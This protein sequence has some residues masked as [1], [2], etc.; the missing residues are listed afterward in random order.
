MRWFHVFTSLG[1]VVCVSGVL[2]LMR[3]D[4]H[5]SRPDPSPFFPASDSEVL[6]RQVPG[7]GSAPSFGGTPIY[8]AC[9]LVTIDSLTRLGVTLNHDRV[10]MHD[11]LDGDV[12]PE[13]AFEQPGDFVSG[14][15]YGLSNG[16]ALLVSVYQTPYI[17]PK[18]LDFQMGRPERAGAPTRTEDGLSIAHVELDDSV[19]IRLWKPGLLVVVTLQ[20]DKP[21]PYG[22]LDAQTFATRL[23]TIAK[24]ALSHGPTAPMRH[25]YTSLLDKVKHPCEVVSTEVFLAS[26]PSRSAA[27]VQTQFH[28][29]ASLTPMERHPESALQGASLCSRH[30][31][32]P[33]GTT[34]KAEYRELDLKITWWDKTQAAVDLN[35]YLCDPADRHPFG[36]PVTVSPSVG[37]GQT[38]LTDTRIDWVL[39]FLVD[40]V[41]VSLDGGALTT[42]PPALQRQAELM[43]AAQAIVSAGV[44]R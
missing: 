27:A 25:V 35:S 1:L 37:T 28:P 42:A 34:N 15:S 33:G 21:G 30:N 5:G 31:I 11:Y 38:C 36:P 12:P 6:L 32:V 13:A 40:N 8:D 17:S 2:L 4:T 44:F 39:N 19:E 24:T 9:A 29:K 10:V 16:N 18:D 22:S 20:T 41:N 23:E 3:P 26:F 7:E 43:P 14:C